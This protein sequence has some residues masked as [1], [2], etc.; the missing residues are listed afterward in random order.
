MNKLLKKFT[1]ALLLTV[2]TLGITGCGNT[3]G[4]VNKNN[5][6]STSS[7][8]NGETKYPVTITDSFG[9]E[10]TLEKEPQKVISIA[11]NI[12]EMIFDLKAEDKLVGRTNY[13]DYPKDAESIESIGT[14]R[15]PDIE[16]IIS[17]EPDLVVASTHFNEENA[18][19]LQEAGIKTISLYEENQVTGV[20]TMIETLGIA[21]NKNDQAKE[22]VDQM[23]KT[24]D[25]VTSAVNGLE[26]PT[27]YY[28]VGYGEGGDFSAPENTF[29]GG[30]IKLAGGKDIVPA[31][32][33]WKFSLE[34]LLEADPYIIV[35][36][37]GEKEQFMAAEGYKEL[38]AVKEGR[39]YEIDNNLID[40]QGYR[41]AE[42]VLTLAKIFHPQAFK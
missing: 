1:V 34:A 7:V 24:I 31:S 33:N 16:K 9:T 11:P 5:S 17:L 25:E 28:V 35:L 36:R 2:F 4:N 32:D 13:C 6:D 20:Y 40:R 14:M 21:L 27:V 37:S 30:L 22:S 3:A 12:T 18:K 41:N 19:K 39:V 29:V 8:T 38:T 15:N 23:K 26:E 42:G 10:I